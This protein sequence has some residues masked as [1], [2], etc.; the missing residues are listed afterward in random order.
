MCKSLLFVALLCAPSVAAVQQAHAASVLD[1]PVGGPPAIR[2]AGKAGGDIT[3]AQWTGLKSV[4]LVGCVPDARIVSLTFCIKDCKGK[5][6]VAGGENGM[7][8]AYQRQMIAN[9]PPGTPFK[10]QVVVRD[11]KGKTWDVPEAHFVWKG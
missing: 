1:A 7:P 11:A 8:T 10:V 2:I 5:D 6:A 9:L 3:A 4:D